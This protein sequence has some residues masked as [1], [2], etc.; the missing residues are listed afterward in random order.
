MIYDNISVRF[1]KTKD[2][3]VKIKLVYKS[4]PYSTSSDEE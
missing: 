3:R 2:V 4:V 1:K